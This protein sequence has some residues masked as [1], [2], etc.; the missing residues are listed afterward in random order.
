MAPAWHT[1][2]MQRQN[3]S[4]GGPYEE[5]YGYSRAV[6]VGNQVHV[7]GTCAQPPNVE[8][9]GAYDQ[10]VDALKTISVALTAAGSSVTDVVRT[11]VYV[12]DLDDADSVMR[13]HGEVVGKI[14]PAC[15]LVHIAGL[16]DPKLL[17]EIE[18]YAVI[19]D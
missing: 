11:R 15:T 3:I 19:S 13:A 8:G 5:P 6:K 7:A 17:V 2:L 18:A 16:L 1:P 10:A 9:V 14:R 12:I 4:S